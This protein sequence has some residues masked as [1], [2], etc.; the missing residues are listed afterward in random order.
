MDPI[1]SIEAELQQLSAAGL[2]RSLREI[3]GSQSAELQVN[4][5]RVINFSSNN[6]LGLA[7]H[8]LLVEAAE[9]SM[10]EGGFGSGASRLIAG[11]LASHRALEERIAAWKQTEAALLFNSGYQANIGL[12][13]ALAGP[14][15]AIFSDQ[16]NHASSI[17]GCRLSPARTVVYPHCDMTK[18]DAL[19][20]EN[21]GRRR[22]IL[23]ESVFSMDGDSPPL[24]DLLEDRAQASGAAL[25]GRGALDRDRGSAAIDRRENGDVRQGARWIRSLCRGGQADR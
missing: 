18:L 12:I 22:L 19:L 2:R 23:T 1:A 3:D 4:G 13:S 7:A 25:C 9:R 15:D 5:R 8:P 21:P 11:N 16:L 20:A 17:D 10:R 6:Y 14:E 24:D